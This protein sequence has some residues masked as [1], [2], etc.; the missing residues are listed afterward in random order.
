MGRSAH[1]KR[2]ELGVLFVAGIGGQRRGS[3]VASLGAALFGWLFR[4][5]RSVDVSGQD[6]P[7]LTNTVLSVE[8]G[9]ADEPAHLLM[10]A[11]L[12]LSTGRRQARWLLAESSWAGAHAPPRFLDLGRWI[13]KVS[14][15]LLVLQFVIPMRRHWRQYR[16]DAAHGVSL[17][18]RLDS[19]AAS[20]CYLALMCVGA[21]SSVLLSAVL[22]ALALAALLPIPRICPDH[23]NP[24]VP[25]SLT[26]IAPATRRNA[27]QIHSPGR[28]GRRERC[29]A[30]CLIPW[31]WHGDDRNCAA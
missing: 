25:A 28:A 16:R 9:G 21:M 7:V 11:T 31:H 15:C 23:G 24:S 22:M 2:A 20:V 19:L 8:A 4:W 3:A 26:R 29:S 17:V 1:G 30:V 10:T 12:P 13:W 14:T 5:N 27:V 6:A 18:A